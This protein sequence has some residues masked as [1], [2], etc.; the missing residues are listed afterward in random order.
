MPTSPDRPGP[1]PSDADAANDAIRAL[2]D[3]ADG[4]WPAEEYER[5]LA[6]WAAA[7]GEPAPL[8]AGTPA[9]PRT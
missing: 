9:K 5:L 7:V 2:V 8:A 4:Q 1:A 6:D 3:G